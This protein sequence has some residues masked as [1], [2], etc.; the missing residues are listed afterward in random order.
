MSG[1]TIDSTTTWRRGKVTF[2]HAAVSDSTPGEMQEFFSR[3]GIRRTDGVEAELILKF[4]HSA[5]VDKA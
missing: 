2:S 3:T 5:F 4:H 1:V